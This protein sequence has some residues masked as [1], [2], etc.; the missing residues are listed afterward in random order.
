MEQLQ[1]RSIE[2]ARKETIAK[3]GGGVDHFIHDLKYVSFFLL[4]VYALIFKLLYLRR[5]SFYVDH[6][7]YTMHLQSFAMLTMGFFCL[8]RSCFPTTS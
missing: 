4:P 5:K 3:L 8:F 6:L 2:E 1:K 7:V